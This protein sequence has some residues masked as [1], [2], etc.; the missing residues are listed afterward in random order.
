MKHKL[1]IVASILLLVL[2]ATAFLDPSILL[3]F[4]NGASYLGNARNSVTFICSTGMNCTKSGQNFTMTA[5]GSGG[6]GDF[7]GPGPSTNNDLV[8]F[9]GTGGKTGKDS[10]IL[11]TNVVTA[12]SPGA[13]LCHFA[14]S[15]QAC[16][17]SAVVNA[18][19]TAGTID[20]TTKVT[21]VLPQANGGTAFALVTQ[22]A[23]ATAQSNSNA[24]GNVWA[25]AV[26]GE[27]IIEA[28]M[29]TT[30][31]CSSVGSGAVTLTLGWTDSA[32]AN[33]K[34]TA[35]MAFTTAARS[36]QSTSLPIWVNST[37]NITWSTTEVQC[38]TPAS[39]STYDVH[40][41]ARRVQ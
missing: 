25:S 19:I 23:N 33:T 12:S 4:K 1:K 14:G 41:V 40:I 29:N 30:S 20:L 6:T 13:G 17:S 9:N 2:V 31:T 16:T 27:Y 34:T 35:S 21:G 11:S 3:Q 26:Q 24:G 5:S 37:T 18:D 32:G 28:Y 7:S 10:G 39:G 8:S 38:T 15:T 36:N 22:A